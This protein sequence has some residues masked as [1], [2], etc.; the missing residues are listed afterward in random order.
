[1]IDIINFAGVN[2]NSA[3][4]LREKRISKYEFEQKKQRLL[5]QIVTE[6][7]VDAIFWN[8]GLCA[9]IDNLKQITV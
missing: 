1:M 7:C 2:L 5:S 9:E 6:D 3:P 8:E 4:H